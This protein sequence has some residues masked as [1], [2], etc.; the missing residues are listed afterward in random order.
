M[1][2]VSQATVEIII[3]L[4]EQGQKSPSQMAVNAIAILLS[5]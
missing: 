4:T 1:P 2:K 3:S 5:R